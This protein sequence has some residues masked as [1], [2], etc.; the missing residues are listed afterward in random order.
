MEEFS[1]SL[2]EK[3]EG[4]NIRLTRRRKAILKTLEQD[5]DNHLSAE[6]IYLKIKQTDNNIGLATV[7]RTLDLFAEAGIIHVLD[8]GDGCR[9]FELISDGTPHYHHHL[10]CLGC[11]KITEFAQDLLEDLEHQVEE[12]TGFSITNHSLRFYG[13]C[14]ECQEK[15]VAIS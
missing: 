9:R 12:K 7:Y 5:P 8:F 3:L 2:Q 6:E 14:H 1:S 10:L 4:Q 11:G 15:R 13:Y